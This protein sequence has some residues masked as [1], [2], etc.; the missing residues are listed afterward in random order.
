MGLDPFVQF[1][2][3]FCDS[4]NS[5]CAVVRVVCVEEQSIPYSTIPYLTPF[6]AL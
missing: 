2:F 5:L 1:R 6:G 3:Y 4:K